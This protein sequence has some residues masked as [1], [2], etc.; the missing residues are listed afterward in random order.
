MLPK[1]DELSAMMLQSLGLCDFIVTQQARKEKRIA[2]ENLS[3][4]STQNTDYNAD[5]DDPDWD[6]DDSDEEGNV[7]YATPLSYECPVLY[8]G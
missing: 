3:D 2:Q 6:E 5:D 7:L 1:N 4:S 8:F